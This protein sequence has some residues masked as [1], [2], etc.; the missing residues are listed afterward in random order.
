MRCFV[1]RLQMALLCVCV[2]HL[3]CTFV[4]I[5]R[6]YLSLSDVFIATDRTRILEI[7]IWLWC[8]FWLLERRPIYSFY[9][10]M[11]WEKCWLKQL[12]LTIASRAISRSTPSNRG[13]PTGLKI[14]TSQDFNPNQFNSKGSVFRQSSFLSLRSGPINGNFC[15]DKPLNI[16]QKSGQLAKIDNVLKG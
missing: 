3:Q 12:R 16:F 8:I 9:I 4:F 7:K 10:W 14:S 15:I 13:S 1:E 6:A 11:E 2:R 5:A